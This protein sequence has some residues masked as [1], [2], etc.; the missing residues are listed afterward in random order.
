MALDIG[1][2]QRM[3]WPVEGRF[4]VAVLLLL[5]L[6]RLGEAV[7]VSGAT[8]VEVGISSGEV[9]VVTVVTVSLTSAPWRMRLLAAF[10]ISR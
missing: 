7:V 10:S 9:T 4:R 3:Q 2:P 8:L 1:P 5:R 6:E